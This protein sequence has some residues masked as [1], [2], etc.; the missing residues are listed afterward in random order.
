MAVLLVVV[1][2]VTTDPTTTN[3][4]KYVELY[5]NDKK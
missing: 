2:P 5:L 1:G 4:P 3:S